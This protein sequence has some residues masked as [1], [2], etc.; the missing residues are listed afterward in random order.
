LSEYRV[1]LDVYN[2]PLD[3][4]LFLIRREEVDIYN[5]PIAR[6][7]E[8]YVAYVELLKELDP[9][10]IGDFLVMAATLM[11]IKSRMLLPKPPPEELEE[12]DLD[13]PRMELVRQLLEY[14]KYKDAA[15]NL[16]NRATEQ[17]MKFPRKPVLPPRDP[18]DIEMENLEI[19]DLFDA[20]NRMLEQTGKRSAVHKV[21]IDDTPVALHADDIVD[22]LERNEGTIRFSRIFE[23]RSR[24]EMIGLFLAVLE[25]MRRHRIR[26]VQDTSRCDIML[27]L[28]GEADIK[29]AF[30][31]DDED[32]ALS[33]EEIAAR[34][35]VNESTKAAEQSP[36]PDSP[37]ADSQ[38]QGP[39]ILKSAEKPVDE[40]LPPALD[41]DAEKGDDVAEAWEPVEQDETKQNPDAQNPDAQN[42]DEQPSDI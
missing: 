6:V 5:I 8:E 28:A 33:D 30:E 21:D 29:A 32:E 19:W 4:L 37:H 38:Q 14:K 31:I 34:L 17:L 3:L 24:G 39:A 23:G 20:F 22:S 41:Q 11:E 26:A 15:G 36:H 9:E 13:D 18:E 25:L 35:G 16:E 12:E 10:A 27:H 40:L 7:T 1:I 42:P 2:G